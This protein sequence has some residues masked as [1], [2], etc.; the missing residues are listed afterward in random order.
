MTLTLKEAELWKIM[1][2]PK[3]ASKSFVAKDDDDEDRQEAYVATWEYL[4]LRKPRRESR[5]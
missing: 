5:K 1:M 3:K 2:R 4:G